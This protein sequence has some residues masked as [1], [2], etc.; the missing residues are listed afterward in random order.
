MNTPDS[1]P[2]PVENIRKYLITVEVSGGRKIKPI[3]DALGSLAYACGG[4]EYFMQELSPG[5]QRGLIVAS[6]LARHT[7]V[8]QGQLQIWAQGTPGLRTVI[9]DLGEEALSP[10]DPNVEHEIASIVFDPEMP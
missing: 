2:V 4:T 7:A 3:A 5:V 1:A 9:E 10:S 8:F 6:I